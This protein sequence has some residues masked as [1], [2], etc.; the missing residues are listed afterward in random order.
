MAIVALVLVCFCSMLVA[1]PVDG[2]P[3]SSGSLIFPA[4]TDSIDNCG[5]CGGNDRA[6]CSYRG[7]SDGSSC[8]CDGSQQPG[9]ACGRWCHETVDGCG[10][11]GGTGRSCCAD[12]S[13]MDVHTGTC[14]PRRFELHV[15][16][17]PA[18]P[19]GFPTTVIGVLQADLLV[20]GVNVLAFPGPVLRF[21][22]GDQVEVTLVN[23]FHEKVSGLHWHGLHQLN[24]A[25]MD[26]TFGIT[27]C[28]VSPGTSFTYA[29]EV[30]QTGSFWYHSHVHAQYTEGLQGAIISEYAEDETDPVQA[31]FPYELDYSIMLMEWFHEPGRDQATHF[32]GPI[33]AFPNYTA[34]YPWP[35]ISALM[36]GRGWFNCSRIHRCEEQVPGAGSGTID[37][38]KTE[39]RLLRRPFFHEQCRSNEEWLP[40]VT[41]HYY[42]PQGQNIRLRLVCSSANIPMRF[43]IDKH[44]LTIVARDGD[45]I[46]P[47]EV[48]FVTVVVGQR[49]DV[50]VPCNAQ[51]TGVNYPV[52]VMYTSANPA[53]FPA[54][55]RPE[56]GLY[57]NVWSFSYLRYT[58]ASDST[59]VDLSNLYS[60]LQAPNPDPE[61]PDVH[62]GDF[63]IFT[64]GDT[65]NEY[66]YRPLPSAASAPPATRRI[67]LD[68]RVIPG[69]SPGDELEWWFTNDESF[70]PPPEPLLLQ[71]YFTPKKPQLIFGPEQGPEPNTAFTTSI[72]NIEQDD[73]V[74]VVIVSRSSQQHPWHLHGYT[75]WF[76]GAEVLV[77][78]PDDPPANVEEIITDFSYS[79]EFGDLSD[80]VSN[81]SLGDSWTVP[82][83]GY[84][85][86]R[87]HANNPGPWLLHCHVDWHLALGMALVLDVHR[88]DKYQGLQKPP[89]LMPVCGSRQRAY[90]LSSASHHGAAT[91]TLAAF[92]TLVV[93]LM[94]H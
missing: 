20:D 73:V 92:V 86:F 40:R 79:G 26:G 2:I 58:S 22:R 11:C 16:D 15:R 47:Y 85:V 67:V 46:Q 19:D 10:V 33:A 42:C 88:N 68:S 31:Q 87:F 37:N 55:E 82:P 89:Q 3:A 49:I 44:N 69:S 21:V 84:M 80:T 29:F 71:K 35:P 38:L 14:G 51:V 17:Y 39:C 94:R 6:C 28:G 56:P 61:Q 74:E 93:F 62:L 91:W 24:N 83:Y 81:V 77:P 45:E 72:I 32:D 60:S 75:V 7:V 1:P 76:L 59:A 41:N 23:D 30:T 18:N 57:D 12:G 53:F 70:K 5:V 36:N 27:E 63:D 78:D 65:L 9:D 64:D 90:A 48:D 66:K 54:P 4:C 43:W 52:F 34:E 8:Q 13:V 50:I 25:W